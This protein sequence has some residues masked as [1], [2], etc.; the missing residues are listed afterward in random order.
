MLIAFDINLEGLIEREKSSTFWPKR[1]R[2][3]E[4]ELNGGGG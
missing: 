2:L 1:E 3:L 4:R